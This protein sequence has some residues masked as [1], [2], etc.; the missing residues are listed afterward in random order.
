MLV[1]IRKV[2]EGVVGDH[3]EGF[4]N[5]ESVGDHEIVLR[6]H[7]PPGAIPPDPHSGDTHFLREDHRLPLPFGVTIML[8]RCRRG[9][10]RKA[11]LGFEGPARVYRFEKWLEEHTPRRLRSVS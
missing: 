8:I 10:H 1:L 7:A 9:K 11:M 3:G 5:V 4:V 6:I 2:G